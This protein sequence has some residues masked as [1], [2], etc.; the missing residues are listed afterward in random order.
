[1]LTAATPHLDGKHVVFGD[2]IDGMSVVRKIEA[3]KTDDRDKPI[4]PVV[5]EDCGQLSGAKIEL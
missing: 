3:T 2:V 4:S 1:M 5:I